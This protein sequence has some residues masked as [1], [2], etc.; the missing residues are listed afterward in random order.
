MCAENPQSVLCVT[1]SCPTCTV[2]A[3][4]IRAHVGLCRPIYQINREIDK[5]QCPCK[6]ANKVKLTVNSRLVLC[7]LR[8]RMHKGTFTAGLWCVLYARPCV[9]T[10]K[11][12]EKNREMS[13][14][15]IQTHEMKWYVNSQFDTR[16]RLRPVLSRRARHYL[17]IYLFI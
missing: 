15:R 14:Q 11:T 13:R 4:Q 10:R 6:K 1:Y 3:V 9:T 12:G 5:I 16:C 8:S 17:F 2:H 7:A